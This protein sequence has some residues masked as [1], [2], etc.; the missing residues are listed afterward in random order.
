MEHSSH[1]DELAR[2]IRE[3]APNIRPRVGIVLGSGLGQFA[4][5]LNHAVYVPYSDLPGFPEVTV[6]GHQG[7]MVIGELFG[8]GVVCLQGRK[9]AYEGSSHAVVKTYIRTLKRLG[10]EYFLQSVLRDR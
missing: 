8:V 5:R 7:T 4:E 2:K 3:R 9:H 1:P 10:C 6:H